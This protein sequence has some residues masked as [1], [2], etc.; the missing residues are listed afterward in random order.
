[1]VKKYGKINIE[2]AELEVWDNP[3]KGHDY[4]IEITCPELSCLCPRSGYP[5]YATIKIQYIPENY[6][7]ELKSLKL[8]INKFRDKYI[9]HEA[10]T[11]KIFSDLKNKLKPKYLKVIGDF[12]PRGNIKT[13]IT[14]ST[15]KNECR[16]NINN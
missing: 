4:L 8:Y 13:I 3:E 16:R 7:V 10:V 6:I 14:V 2:Q 5:D 9:S 1:M 11:N 12:N 15:D